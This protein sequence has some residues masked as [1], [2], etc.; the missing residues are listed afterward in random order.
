MSAK[1]FNLKCL[2]VYYVC[3]ESFKILYIIISTKWSCQCCFEVR[4]ESNLKAH[5]GMNVVTVSATDK[6]L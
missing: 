6:Y 5:N 3:L 4:P 2:V 1:Y